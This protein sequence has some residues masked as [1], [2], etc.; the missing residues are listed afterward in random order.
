MELL[1]NHLAEKSLRCFAYYALCIP[2]MSDSEQAEAHKLHGSQ[3]KHVVCMGFPRNH[4]L[5][6]AS[7]TVGPLTPLAETLGVHHRYLLKG[8]PNVAMIQQSLLLNEDS[9]IFKRPASA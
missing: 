9:Y 5:F 3:V 8:R 7:R 6:P 2:D 1:S 4:A